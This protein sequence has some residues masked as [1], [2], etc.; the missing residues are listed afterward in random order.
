[1]TQSP[2]VACHPSGIYPLTFQG[3]FLEVISVL[4]Q[5]WPQH[6]CFCSCRSFIAKSSTRG[7]DCPREDLRLV[8]ADCA[9][10]KPSLFL[11]DIY[12]F[13]RRSYLEL[14]YC[15]VAQRRNFMEFFVWLICCIISTTM[16]AGFLR[17]MCV[18]ILYRQQ[19]SRKYFIPK[20]RSA[21]TSYN[22]AFF[23]ISC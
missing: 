19:D 8:L 23:N 20:F 21:N 13:I 1:M 17:F 6:S 18:K 16:K 7:V 9:S 2:E 5:G 12:L 4:V 22:P 11:S 10:A 15:T 3:K 14:N